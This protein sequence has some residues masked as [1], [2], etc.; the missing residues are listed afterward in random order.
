MLARVSPGQTKAQTLAA[1]PEV[2]PS[3]VVPLAAGPEDVASPPSKPALPAAP[4]LA[5]AAP[6]PIVSASNET[7]ARARLYAVAR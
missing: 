4:A 5:P 3:S 2:T 1:L 6:A 7:Q